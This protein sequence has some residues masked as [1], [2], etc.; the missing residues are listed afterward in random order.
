MQW[1]RRKCRSKVLIFV[2]FEAF[3]LLL[4]KNSVRISGE[5]HG[6]AVERDDRA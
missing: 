2:V 3:K 1:S 5:E 6:I 4:P